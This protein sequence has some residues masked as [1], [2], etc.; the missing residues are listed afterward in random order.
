MN[1]LKVIQYCGQILQV[2]ESEEDLTTENK[3]TICDSASAFLKSIFFTEK[4]LDMIKNNINKT[5]EDS[6]NIKREF[7]A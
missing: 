7:D 5:L 6:T 2:L 4:S 3:I 1:E